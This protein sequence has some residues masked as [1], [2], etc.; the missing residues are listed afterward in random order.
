MRGK[1]QQLEPT[2][3]HGL[4]GNSV[5]CGNTFVPLCFLPNVFPHLSFLPASNVSSKKGWQL[6]L[7]TETEQSFF[8]LFLLNVCCQHVFQIGC[9]QNTS[10][11]LHSVD[12]GG[13]EEEVSCS[14]HSRTKGILKH[15]RANNNRSKQF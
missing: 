5:H 1:C 10:V 11:L 8:P 4:L 15:S 2:S 13:A 14:N 6:S 9:S 3:D 12:L 7:K